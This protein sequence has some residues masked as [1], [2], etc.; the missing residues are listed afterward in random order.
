MSILLCA[1]TEKELAPT[2]VFL[3]HTDH[4]YEVDILITG[5]GLSSSTYHLT[6]QIYFKMPSFIIQAGVA[7][8]LDESLH[9]GE[10]VIVEKD[11]IGDE[12]VA[13]KNEF[14]SL[15]QLGL[16]DDNNFPWQEGMLFNN[17]LN[18]FQDLNLSAVT[19]VTVNEIT[20]EGKRI[21]YYKNTLD[22]DIETLEGA[23]LHYVALMENI[24]FLQLRSISNYVGERDKTKWMLAESIINLNIALQS[25]LPKVFS[26]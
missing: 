13:E 11:Q 19:G 22:A 18:L 25:V 10:V 24:L 16:K 6:K 5:V 12:G 9:L 4:D 15:F 21:S 14:K 2:N 17:S 26:V 8:S 20:T 7:G 23:A 3:Q 1:A